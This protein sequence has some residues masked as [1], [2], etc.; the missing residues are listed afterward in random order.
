[1]FR[2]AGRLIEPIDTRGIELCKYGRNQRGKEGELELH[3]E[4]ET[5]DGDVVPNEKMIAREWIG[6]E[7]ARS[8]GIRSKTLAARIL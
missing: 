5:K 1:V 3:V 7:V 2:Q 4:L 6:F 8:A